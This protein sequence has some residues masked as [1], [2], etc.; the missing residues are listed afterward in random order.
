MS[1]G[2]EW[3]VASRWVWGRSKPALFA[4][5]F[6]SLMTSTVGAQETEIK[7]VLVFSDGGL[8]APAMTLAVQNIHAVLEA[9]RPY[10]IEYYE[11]NLAFALFPDDASQTSFR[12][13][14]VR[15]YKNRKPDVIIAAGQ[16]SIRSVMESHETFFP[17]V[18]I[19]F[20][21][22]SP[23]LYNL[24]K[25]G[26]DFTGT[27]VTYDAAKTV[28]AALR[29]R[30]GTKQVFVVGGAS[31]FD[32]RGEALV[33][34]S[35]RTYEGK[36]QITYLTD[37]DV[38]TLTERLKHL[39]DD[40]V[41]L[42]TFFLQDTTGRHFNGNRETVHL[43]TEA[44]RVPVFVLTDGLVGYGAAG[45]YVAS[46]AQ[47]GQVAGGMALR[48]LRG[49]KPP[50]AA[51]SNAYIF[52]W[53]V[54]QRWGI[55]EA[56]LP[57]G[58]IVL[59]RQPSVWESYRRYIVGGIFLCL[60][61]ASL[62][63]GLLWQ[64]EK[65]RKIERSLFESLTFER[66][67]SELS[68]R[69]IGLP[70]DQLEANI[71]Q[72]LGRIAEFLKMD[73]ITL[74]E[75]SQDRTEMTAA[76]SW[77]GRGV[78]P[79]PAHVKAADLPW[80]RNRLLRGEMAL[81]P[82]P[83]ALPEEAR[84]EKEYFRKMGILS[85]VSIPIE[86]GGEIIGAIS[87]VS[88]KCQIEL[89]QDLLNQFRVLGDVFWNAL[90]RKRFVEELHV[91]QIVLRESEDRFRLVANTAPVL[92]WMSGTD[93]RCTF[94]NQ[95]WLSFTG[96]SLEQEL[97]EGW[98][99][100][101]HGDDLEHC[102][103]TYSAAFDAR[104]EFEMEYRLRRFDGAYRWLVDYG[105]PRFETDGTFCGYIGSCVDINDRK[106]SE[107]SLH[108]LS[109]LLINAQEGERARIAR[110]LHDDFSQRLAVLSIGLDRLRTMLPESA[111]D[112]RATIAG[113]LESSN[114]LSSDLHAL[115]HQ[116]H[117]SK[118]ELL[119]LVAALR[120]LCEELSER[121]EIQVQ[122]TEHGF[123]AKIPREIALCLFRVAQEALGNVV[124]HSGAKSASVT[125]SAN[126]NGV[127]LRISDEGT[128]FDTDLMNQV[129]GIGL[130]GMSERLRI[131][132]GRLRVISELSKGT[133]ILAEA[134]LA[135]FADNSHTKSQ[136]VRK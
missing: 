39:P 8:S 68:A 17:H 73:R 131:V 90:K 75:F 86:I 5:A 130:R 104:T 133:E 46:Y 61:E 135:A 72:G 44:A 64:R 7:R 97:G 92:I 9:G 94:F 45:G 81:A 91:S 6:C 20:C 13:F 41:V 114:E 124:K 93:K 16:A 132:G 58:S 23:Q 1:P 134:P 78:T 49:E 110:E 96:R 100:G 34:E 15:K 74:F 53:R 79:A 106:L 37:L 4:L 50:G 118:L 32:R 121:Y 54:L 107:D 109:G 22:T 136:A 76:F 12:D 3:R 42:F 127:S 126:A 87:F 128:G 115:S 102:L 82:S 38:S 69:F 88:T 120:G 105:V 2:P 33:K 31:P 62:I 112:E 66:L 116:L 80:W 122:F 67:L 25:L 29:L 103:G 56:A 36:L 52:D 10:H 55:K 47:Q 113:M 30:P 129:R 57:P 43:V 40:A 111:T 108:N 21:C 24:P 119:G 14:Y 84:A 71:E 26:N 65:R 89:T 85:A 77:T 11:E 19:V 28:D 63:L 123:P 18:P 48:I 59:N 27:W 125:L 60:L 83:N 98:V 35:L 101:V 51:G 70:E 95:G 117:S 99:S